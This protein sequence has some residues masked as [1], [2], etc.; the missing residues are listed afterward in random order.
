[1][2]QS[3]ATVLLVLM[4]LGLCLFL[5]ACSQNKPPT[6]ASLIEAFHA[7]RSAHEHLHEMLL[8]DKQVQIV[9]SWGVETTASKVP[10]IPPTEDLSAARFQEYLEALK[11]AGGAS[12]SRARGEDAD[13]DVGVWAAGWA[14]DTRHVSICYRA[15]P[16]VNQVS[17]LDAYH[18]GSEK[19][20]HGVFRHIE[21]RWY[22]WADW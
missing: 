11:Q 14:G 18:E 12:A 15:R 7:H 4:C 19:Q 6:E 17:G 1:M 13:T 10:K 5:S 9:A 22:I 8:A 21:G 16:P 20:P 3:Y 2:K